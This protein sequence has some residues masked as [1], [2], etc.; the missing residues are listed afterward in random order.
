MLD[1][2]RIPA[3]SPDAIMLV[4]AMVAAIVE[5][6]G[7]FDRGPGPSAT[8]ADFSPPTGGFLGLYEDDRPVAGGGVKR[9]TDSIAEITRMYVVPDRRGQGLARRLLVELEALARE[10]G[11][12][13]VRL[14][15]G[16]QQPHAR[17]LYDSTGY[18]EIPDY[19]DNPYA[20]FWGEKNL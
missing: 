4:E 17:A 20:S 16:N 19:N 6:Y 14:D 10:L 7:T 13:V 1:V 8:P 5:I 2:R 3:D 18:L 12:T 9:L 11:Y 15:T